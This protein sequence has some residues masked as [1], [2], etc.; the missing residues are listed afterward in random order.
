MK[1]KSNLTFSH[2]SEESALIKQFSKTINSIIEQVIGERFKFYKK[3]KNNQKLFI[4]EHKDIVKVFFEEVIKSKPFITYGEWLDR[5]D[6]FTND[7]NDW[8]FDYC[9]NDI[10]STEKKLPDE[11]GGKNENRTII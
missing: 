5:T 6:G 8:L 4:E 7:Y 3:Y 2:D 1:F 10:I 9:F 11:I